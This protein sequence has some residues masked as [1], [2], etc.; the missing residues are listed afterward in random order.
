[1]GDAQI[2]AP[3][4]SY[5]MDMA[6]FFAKWLRD[7]TDSQHETGYVFDVNPAIVVD[8]PSKAG[9]GDAVTV[10]PMA[11]YNFYNDKA[12]LEDNYEGMKAWVEYMR[13]KSVDHIYRWSE[14]EGE[15]EGYGDWIAVEKSPVEPISAAYYFYSTKLLSEAAEITGKSQDAKF[16]SALADSIRDAF[17]NKFF[18][19]KNINYPSGTQTANLLPLSFG[20]TPMEY[21][22]K[23]AQN[24]IDDVVARGK[25]PSTGFLGTAY[26][27]PVLSNYG[28]H[29]LAFETAINE[30]YPS[31]GYMVRNGATSMWEL[32]NSDTEPPDRMNSRNHFALGSVGEWYYSHLAGIRILEP[33]F[34]KILIKPKPAEG[35]DWVTASYK[36]P[37][38]KV[39]SSWS[40]DG[41]AFHMDIRIPA[42]T[43]SEVIIPLL[44]KDFKSLAESG[45]IIYSKGE[46]IESSD[47]QILEIND[48]NIILSV[49][50]GDYAFTIM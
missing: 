28:E 18:D 38:G 29:Q 31:W 34:K 16:Y 47:I 14:K 4:A 37:Y 25:H 35:L 36:T 12:I 45:K 26:L 39:K 23:I 7:I 1:M 19:E 33:G 21:K 17:H 24:V 15:W 43:T 41:N 30:E 11:M 49:G 48:E 10:V 42:N 9:W 20:L 32:W 50:S 3:T 13:K 2:F 44:N 6:G 46:N 22:D 40:K 8:G 5:N 27:L